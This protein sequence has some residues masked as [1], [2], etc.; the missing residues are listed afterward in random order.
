M[1]GLVEQELHIKDFVYN[2]DSEITDEE[3]IQEMAVDETQIAGE[4]HEEAVCVI[5]LLVEL[6]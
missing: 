5:Q 3:E 1:D 4:E 2:N 6:K